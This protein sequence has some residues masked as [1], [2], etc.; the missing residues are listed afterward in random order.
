MVDDVDDVDDRVD[1][2][3]IWGWLKRKIFQVFWRGFDKI[4]LALQPHLKSNY[5]L[6]YLLQNREL[7][8]YLPVVMQIVLI[9]VAI[10]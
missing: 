2:E 5:Q 7:L 10:Y 6:W 1:M 3:G 8:Y 9:K 4:S